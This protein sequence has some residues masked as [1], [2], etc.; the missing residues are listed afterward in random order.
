M[1]YPSDS[2]QSSATPTFDEPETAPYK[3]EVS[4]ALL[5]LEARLG[6]LPSSEEKIA[7][8]LAFMRLAISQEGA[9]HFRDFWEARR[10]VLPLFKAN[11]N[12]AIRSALWNECVELT[13]E[14]RRLKEMLEEQSAFAVE[15]IELAIAGLEKEAIGI[16]E[17]VKTASPIEFLSSSR[18]IDA[19]AESYQVLQREL[20][21]L[22]TLATRLNGLRKEIVNTDMR[23]RFKT[24]FFKRLSTLGDQIFPRRK[25]LIDEISQMF[26]RDVNGFIAAHF[27][28][29]QAV[30]APYF[31]LR[32]EIKAL[33]AMAKVFTLSSGAFNRT[34]LGLSKCWDQVR[35]LEK[36]YKKGQ[37]AEREA[38]ASLRDAFIAKVDEFAKL[39]EG[40]QLLEVE[41]EIDAIL[42]E[43]DQTNLHRQD[44]KELR[45]RLLKLR[46]PH[47]AAQEKKAKE[48]E[49][50]E[51]EAVRV[52]REA[53]QS[54][55]ERIAQC[56]RE[57]PQME[58]K[59]LESALET[60]RQEVK[61]LGV[62]KLENQQ[63]ER[64]L[65]QLK[66][67]AIERKERSLLNIDA[68]DLEALQALQNALDQKKER[69]REIK[70]QLEQHRRA[71]SASNLDFE[72]AM[73]YRELL[74]QEKT[75]LEKNNVGIEEIEQKIA[76]LST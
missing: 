53:T 42:D 34:R 13:Q 60:F 7:C 66:D 41:R 57:G 25:T 24:K 1:N 31:V 76:D 26:E 22:N 19:G 61:E 23:I 68:G 44:F 69:R 50:A 54:L 36:E 40:L 47:L 20:S 8:G 4:A 38:S 74:E 10:L 63:I 71:L 28:N 65:R 51:K 43:M 17:L 2:S 55:K 58:P 32:E 11:V 48:L 59:V 73:L 9:A 35:E 18:T 33:Q 14:A 45:A 62:P 27:Q 46:A 5:D 49:D 15:Q 12:V 16:A 30:G 21:V 6:K 29:N 64:S 67:M 56:L 37:E 39:S 52:K 75:L 3:R 70:E 72:K